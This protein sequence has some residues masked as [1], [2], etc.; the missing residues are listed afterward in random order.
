MTHVDDS[1]CQI[2]NTEITQMMSPMLDL[3]K[4]AYEWSNCSVVELNNF[5]R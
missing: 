4:N 3:T 2:E 5:L 1:K